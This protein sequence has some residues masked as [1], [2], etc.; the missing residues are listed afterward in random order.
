MRIWVRVTDED[1]REGL[2]QIWF[3]V[4]PRFSSGFGLGLDIDGLI[5][6]LF[7]GLTLAWLR[8]WFRMRL[9]HA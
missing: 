3:G 1:L 9:K 2:G 5:E 4:T 6:D 8:V 7:Q